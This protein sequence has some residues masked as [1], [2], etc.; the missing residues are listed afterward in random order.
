MRDHKRCPNAKLHLPRTTSVSTGPNHLANQGKVYCGALGMELNSADIEIA[1]T[2]S[3]LG[4]YF[5][6]APGI[7]LSATMIKL[8]EK[9]LKSDL[10]ISQNY[11]IK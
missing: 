7:Q 11:P 3:L 9:M 4:I 10:E 5:G 2:C 8:C 1:R 6:H